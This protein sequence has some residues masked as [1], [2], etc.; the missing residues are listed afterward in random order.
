MSNNTQRS[1]TV[2]SG[3]NKNSPAAY[4]S[5]YISTTKYSALSFLPFSLWNQFK[6]L[7]NIY[8][9]IIAILQ[10]LPLSPLTPITAIVPLAAVLTISMVRE[11]IEDCVRNRSDRKVNGSKVM[12]VKNGKW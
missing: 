9:L 3:G 5:N 1:F 7:A 2:D 12:V 10:S 4:A 11:A 8:F 6:N